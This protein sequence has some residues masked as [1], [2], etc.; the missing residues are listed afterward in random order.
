MSSLLR[1]E[2]AVPITT[3]VD[4][5]NRQK[6]ITDGCIHSCLESSKLQCDS[7]DVKSQKELA[8]RR[9]IAFFRNTIGAV[10]SWGL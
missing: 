2:A 5:W 4:P 1:N 9:F 7:A 10:E 8:C 3:T 6:S